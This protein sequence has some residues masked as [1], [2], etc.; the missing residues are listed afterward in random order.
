VGIPTIVDELA[1]DGDPSRVAVF[2]S[3]PP[4][5][6]ATGGSDDALISTGRNTTNHPELLE[7]HEA[8]ARSF[9]RGEASGPAPSY[10]DYRPDVHT[11]ALALPYLILERPRFLF[12]GLGD[13]DEL[14]H[15]NDYPGYLASLRSADALIGDVAAVLE[16]F[17][18]E[19][20]ST[21]LVV[22]SDHGRSHV[23]SEHG[24]DHPESAR[25][26]LLAAGNVIHARGR[27][28]SPERRHLANVV[29]TVRAAMGM[30]ERGP[31]QAMTELFRYSDHLALR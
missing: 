30:P 1:K 25:V 29:P 7:R 28:D 4:I 20:Y 22:T 8:T 3:W 9:A 2:A 31:S 21:L 13:T 24:R 15:K 5:A 12:I 6:K 27:I 17:E 14:A 26:W 11:G 19:G 23:F 18:K 16:S 10:G